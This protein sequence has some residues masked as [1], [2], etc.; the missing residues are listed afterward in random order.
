MRVSKWKS[1]KFKKRNGSYTDLPQVEPIYL[2][3]GGFK[4]LKRKLE[5]LKNVLPE[6]IAETARTAAFGDRSDNAEY[7]AAKGILRRT[8]YQ[9]IEIQEQIKRV[10]VIKKDSNIF[11]KVQLGSTV[12]IENDGVRQTYQILGPQ[13]TNPSKGS[14][15]Y[16]SPLGAALMN[17]KQDDVVMIH[18]PID[19]GAVRKYRILKIIEDNN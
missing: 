17:H 1:E 3:E 13:E 11:G 9:I 7:K 12:I 2:T 19:G 14:I 15:S 6:R 5:Q 4:L 10:V 16:Q 8:N 18:L